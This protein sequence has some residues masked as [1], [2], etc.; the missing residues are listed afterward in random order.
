M[1]VQIRTAVLAVLALGVCS[2]PVLAQGKV[3]SKVLSTTKTSTM[4]KE[5][6]EAGDAGFEYK[7]QTAFKS[8]FGGK[9]V[10]TITGS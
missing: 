5:L 8:G 7:G 1:T 3:E 6:Q 4:Q 10:V 9:E 2:A